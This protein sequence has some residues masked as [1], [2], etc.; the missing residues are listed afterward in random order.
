MLSIVEK[1]STLNFVFNS[2]IPRKDKWSIYH[3]HKEIT[4]NIDCPHKQTEIYR[5]VNDAYKLSSNTKG[6]FV[7]AGCYKGGS[8]AK[9][10]I[11]AERLKRELFVFDS[12]EGLPVHNE[13][14]GINIY[15]KPVTFEIGEYRGEYN[16]VLENV[17]TYGHISSCTF[18][19]GWFENTMPDFK[20]D[21]AMAYIDVDLVASVSTCFKY[22]YP[23]LVSGGVI[24]CHDGHL[25]LIIELLGDDE[26]W[27]NEVGCKKPYIEGLGNVKLIKL[28]KQ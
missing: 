11:V 7:E 27:K 14:H 15:N 1:K 19:K 17:K 18:I 28:I 4:R 21:I 26:Y 22:I 5:F 25:P 16:E 3:K 12:F 13:D 2:S 6:C 20:E 10:S 9:F 24:Y 8:T 23:L